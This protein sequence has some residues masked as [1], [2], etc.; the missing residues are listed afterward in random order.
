[1][2]L[3]LL[4]AM[5]YGVVPVV[6]AIPC[7]ISALGSNTGCLVDPDD[8]DGYA[9]A[10]IHLHCN[11]EELAMK[12]RCA[13]E[14]ILEKFS[15]QTWAQIWLDQVISPQV[16]SSKEWPLPRKIA[17]PLGLEKSLGFSTA[18]RVLRRL[19]KRLPLKF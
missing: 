1:M 17:P 4:E 13:R 9:A 8:V 7:C 3:S 6:S 5:A 16:E 19:H 12:S 18:G 10:M 11:R 14:R 2:T 15:V